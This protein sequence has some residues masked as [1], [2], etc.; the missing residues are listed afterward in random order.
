MGLTLMV[1]QGILSTWRSSAP[2]NNAAASDLRLLWQTGGLGYGPGQ[3]NTPNG[4]C[5]GLDDEILV[6]DTNN[7]RIQVLSA[8]ILVSFLILLIIIYLCFNQVH[9]LITECLFLGAFKNQQSV[10]QF[11][12]IRF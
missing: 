12:N 9:A 8:I 1:F 4:F 3:F 7:H 11:W 6:A 2:K 10:S 5:L